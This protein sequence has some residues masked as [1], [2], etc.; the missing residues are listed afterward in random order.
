MCKFSV[1]CLVPRG[2]VSVIR[3]VK[4]MDVLA[5]NTPFM[6]PAAKENLGEGESPLLQWGPGFMNQPLKT[7]ESRSVLAKQ[8]MDFCMPASRMC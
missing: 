4:F 3:R 1:V 6:Q 8:Q 2:E 5:L 7:A